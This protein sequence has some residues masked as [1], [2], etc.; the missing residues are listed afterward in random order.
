[1]KSR[2]SITGVSAEEILDSRGN[3]TLSVT[4]S[5]DAASGTFSVPSGAST[6]IHEAWEKRDGD[7]KRFRGLGVKKA[8]AG[9]RT[10]LARKVKGKDVRQQKELDALLCAADGTP[11]KR[12]LGANAL[13]GVS[14]A[15]AKAAAAA[16][17]LSMH[18][19]LSRM[20]K[21]KP[22]AP[23]LFMNVINAGKHAS[24][25]LAFQEYMI[26]SLTDTVEEGLI[27]ADKIRAELRAQVKKRYSPF[28]ANYGDEGGF[29]I[30]ARKVAEP[31]EI[32]TN[33]LAK[34]HL[35]GKVMLAIDSAA[36]SFYRN[37]KYDVDGKRMAQ[38]DLLKLYGAL[39]KKYPLISIEDPFDEED[40]EG[41]ARLHAAHR[42]IKVIGDDLTVTNPGRL[43]QA[44]E[45]GS[46]NGIIIK[47]NQ[48]GTLSE[49]LEV[50]KLADAARI[51]CVVSHR[52]GETNDDFIADLAYAFGAFGLK[53]GAPNRGERLAKYNRLWRITS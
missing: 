25:Y 16:E 34:L 53:A 46:I 44:L 51:A 10:V 2:F 17:G 35:K 15:S 38:N 27:V 7:Q 21:T 22:Q 36:S 26:V 14:I 4:V 41:F 3:P 6:G 8:V 23:R 47:P 52:S 29:V 12:R 19:Y 40:F 42:G 24:S 13:L 28:S 1:M 48:I 32:L 39:I 33:V 37:G 43:E 18:G 49:T 31:L 9:V 30:Q 50:M 5:T 20:L 11:N 45:H